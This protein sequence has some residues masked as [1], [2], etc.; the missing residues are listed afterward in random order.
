[1]LRVIEQ[2]MKKAELLEP[3]QLRSLMMAVRELKTSLKEWYG[4]LSVRSCPACQARLSMSQLEQ[5]FPDL[6]TLLEKIDLERLSKIV[7]RPDSDPRAL[8]SEQQDRALREA[9]TNRRGVDPRD[10]LGVSDPRESM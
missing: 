8:P 4:D 5:R 6:V 10:F 2:K 1:M 7:P 3:I 9:V